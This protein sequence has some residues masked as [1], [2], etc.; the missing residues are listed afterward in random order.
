MALRDTT[1][2]LAF[3]RIQVDPRKPLPELANRVLSA[4]ERRKRATPRP[5]RRK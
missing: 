5:P 4:L 2:S 1:M 3:E